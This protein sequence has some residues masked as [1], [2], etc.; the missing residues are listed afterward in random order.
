MSD[1]HTPP[2]L[3]APLGSMAP[4]DPPEPRKT[5]RGTLVIAVVVASF[6]VVMTF[7]LFRW[8]ELQTFSED[9]RFEGYHRFTGT[10]LPPLPVSG[11][12]LL[13]PRV[14][15]EDGEELVLPAVPDLPENL[16]PSLASWPETA[17]VTGHARHHKGF[18]SEL[19]FT[20]D[21]TDYFYEGDAGWVVRPATRR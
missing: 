8:Y 5:W 4:P 10:M 2:E 18:L 11:S 12:D 16:G 17:C 6:G 14:R 20:I 1:R 15:T 9:L 19:L 21:G 3:R 7:V 13:K